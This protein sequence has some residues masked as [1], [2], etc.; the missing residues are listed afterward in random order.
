MFEA[1]LLAAASL[2]VHV[3]KRRFNRLLRASWGTTLCAGQES[4]AIL[5]GMVA[6]GPIRFLQCQGRV[7][8]VRHCCAQTCYTIDG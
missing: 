5:D 7:L 3:L 1:V 2:G 6:Y 8:V 4:S